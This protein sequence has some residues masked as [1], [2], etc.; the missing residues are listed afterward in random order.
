MT[1]R[2]RLIA[3]LGVLGVVLGARAIHIRFRADGVTDA[4]LPYVGLA[5]L[6]SLVVLISGTP[7]TTNRLS[8]TITT[9]L[10][11]SLVAVGVAA[12]AKLVFPD[13]LPRF[14]VIASGAG[15]FVW[16][17]LTGMAALV[18]TRRHGLIERVVAIVDA[19]DATELRNDAENQ[20]RH[21]MPFVLVE[22]IDD[23]H[24]TA[25]LDA[26]RR[27]QA[28]LLVLS[29]RASIDPQL[30][31]QAE[32]LHRS[33]VKVRLLEDFYDEWLGKLPVSSLDRFALMGDIESVHGTY[34][35]LKRGIDL[36]CAAIGVVAVVAILPF[37][38]L[39][40]LL[41]NRGPLFFR[42]ERVGK[43][44]IEFSILKFRSMAVGAIDVS[45]WTAENDPRITP[46]GRLLR[47]THIDELPQVFN[48]FAGQL[49]IVGPRPEQVRYVREL[50]QKLPF[51]SARHLVTPGLTGWA[52]VKYRYAASEED[53]YVK[54]QY[55]LYYLRHQSLSTDLRIMWMTARQLL[56][57]G[58]R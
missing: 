39:G 33:G 15:L 48:V 31:D 1:Q 10:G 26:C 53:A 44:D 46:F 24:S 52:Q 19:D 12:V 14:V 6:M 54:L 11:T 25:V 47:K 58:G 28:T 42:Q 29:Q 50:E 45:G 32:T 41:A 3:A 27:T 57:G 18:V 43:D 34:S 37:I 35:S 51:Y 40:N 16:L 56:L 2:L 5:A 17:L 30:V 8:R 13:R 23:L 22:V 20:R 49:S 21:E 4:L 9:S 7:V 38:L 55:D 36:V